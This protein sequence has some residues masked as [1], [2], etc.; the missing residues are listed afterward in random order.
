MNIFEQYG[1]RE[2]ADVTIYQLVEENGETIEKPY[3]FLDTLKVSTLEQ[4]AEEVEA[5]GGIGNAPIIMWEFGK[6]IEV[7]LEDALYTPRSMAMKFG[8]EWE[9]RHETITICRQINT[10]SNGT[11]NDLILNKNGQEIKILDGGSSKNPSSEDLK[12]YDFN[13]KLYLESNL[14]GNSTYF[15]QW[16]Q[17]V[18]NDSKVLKINASDFP[19]TY[20]LVG[21]TYIRNRDSGKDEY[22]QFTVP[23]AK[24]T[25]ENA[26][27][28]ESDGDP[29][30]LNL[31][32]RVLNPDEGPMIQLAQFDLT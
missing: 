22:F 13:G 26:I 19:G 4:T 25:S 14:L 28:L 31:K 20:K 18:S 2:V 27:T 8:S 11:F 17:P 29:S 10:K 16:K 15:V 30:V 9:S 23:R 32:M 24:L 6:E 21:E 1:I 12:I 5:K 7:L 3:L